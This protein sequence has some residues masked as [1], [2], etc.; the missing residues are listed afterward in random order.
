M[1]TFHDY[2]THI[3]SINLR[4]YLT[5]HFVIFDFLIFFSS[6][7]YSINYPHRVKLIY[8][9][10][11]CNLWSNCKFK[12][13]RLTSQ[14]STFVLTG[15]SWILSYFYLKFHLAFAPAV[16]F[17]SQYYI[18]SI[19]YNE[20]LIYTRLFKICI[21]LILYT[22]KRGNKNRFLCIVKTVDIEW[23]LIEPS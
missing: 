2:Y 4:I 19:I 8:Q 20:K 7:S 10:T 13:F 15:N 16:L 11:D 23:F 22:I 14:W 12:K 17:N 1:D 3:H 21:V 5:Y 6:L 18:N 9:M